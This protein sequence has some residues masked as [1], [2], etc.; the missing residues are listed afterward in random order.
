MPNKLLVILLRVVKNVVIVSAHLRDKEDETKTKPC[1]AVSFWRCFCSC[2]MKTKTRQWQ[3]EEERKTRWRGDKDETKMRWR[4]RQRRRQR[5]RQTR[6]KRR[7]RKIK[8]ERQ[9]TRDDKD[10]DSKISSPPVNLSFHCFTTLSPSK[11]FQSLSHNKCRTLNACQ[12]Y[13]VP[14]TYTS[15]M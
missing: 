10:A 13:F 9:E 14:I 4:Q 8:D 15:S 5:Q 11:N 7:R 12:S 2:E 6:N 3:G 1:C